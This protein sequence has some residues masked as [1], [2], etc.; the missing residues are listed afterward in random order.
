[1]E[2]E[3]KKC[4]LCSKKAV[5][6]HEYYMLCENCWKGVKLEEEQKNASKNK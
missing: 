1:M 2:I 4:E 6:Y 3:E 5:V